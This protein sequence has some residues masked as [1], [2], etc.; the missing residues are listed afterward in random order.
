MEIEFLAR[1]LRR[2]P[3]KECGMCIVRDDFVSIHKPT[4][5]IRGGTGSSSQIRFIILS[6]MGIAAVG[7]SRNGVVWF[8]H[9][10]LSMTTG[11]VTFLKSF[12]ADKLEE[13]HS[14]EY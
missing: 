3:L 13:R 12:G 5:L 4:R 9:A 11:E 7:K 14:F 1:R 10:G 2:L 8:M 6:D